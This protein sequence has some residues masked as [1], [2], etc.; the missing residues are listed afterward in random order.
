[1]AKERI[2]RTFVSEHDIFLTKFDKKH[3]KKSASQQ[4]EIDKHARIFALRDG[5]EKAPSF[6]KRLLRVF[7]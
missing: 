4:K 2:N 5:K 1:M 7:D 3:P 6:I